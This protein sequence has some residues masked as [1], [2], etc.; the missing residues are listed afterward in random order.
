[1]LFASCNATFLTE[2]S[3]WM[4]SP[5]TLTVLSLSAVALEAKCVLRAKSVLE[6]GDLISGPI[7]EVHV[8]IK[9]GRV[10]NAR[11]SAK[12]VRSVKL[13]RRS[14]ACLSVPQDLL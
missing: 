7:T 6:P 8:P 9:I 1:M 2:R 3:Q 12:T 5:V 14:S 10:P 13:L 11:N 4:I